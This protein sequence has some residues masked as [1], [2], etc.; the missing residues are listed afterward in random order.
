MAND[1]HVTI[2]GTVLQDPT[3]R[4]TSNNNTMLNIRVGVQTTKQKEGEKYPQ[5][6]IYDVVCF[7]KSAEYLIG[8]VA[9]KTKLLVIGD[10][11]MGEPWTDRN[12]VTHINPRVNGQ[13]IK[14]LSNGT[15][16]SNASAPVMANNHAT[17]DEM[18]F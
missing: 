2:V 1:A 11:Q 17:D 6:D 4:Q 12:G 3:N 16:D 13:T 14:I 7:G 9:K 18:P 10:M 5:S 8:K 15:T